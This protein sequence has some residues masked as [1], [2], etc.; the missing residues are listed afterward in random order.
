MSSN[1]GRGAWRGY[2]IYVTTDSIIGVNG[3][4]KEKFAPEL[5]AAL[6]SVGG[7]FIGPLLAGT[8][9]ATGMAIG[10]KLS[11]DDVAKAIKLIEEKKDLEVRKENLKEV[12]INRKK[13]ALKRFLTNWGDLTIKTPKEIYT[14]NLG[15][16]GDQGEVQKLKDIFTMFDRSKFILEDK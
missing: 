7:A 11:E 13:V 4:L 8:G 6:F 5:G 15:I 12:R 16:Q 9:A 10:Q 2:G 3:G 14:I 1:I